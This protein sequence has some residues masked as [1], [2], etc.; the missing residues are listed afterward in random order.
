M[1][2]G[3]GSKA[4]RPFLRVRIE[5]DKKDYA[6]LRLTKPGFALML[7]SDHDR[8]KERLG[9]DVIDYYP[10]VVD[11]R[12]YVYTEPPDGYPL[13]HFVVARFLEGVDLAG[14][15]ATV[16]Y[17]NGN[18]FDLRPINR[19]VIRKPPPMTTD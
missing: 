8:V 7:E 17:K 9:R 6:L 18:T 5:G 13:K 2:G 16:R 11:G 15:D 10:T 14:T 3:K 19:R 12:T 4:K 1:S